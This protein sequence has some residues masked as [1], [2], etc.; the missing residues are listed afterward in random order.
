LTTQLIARLAACGA[1]RVFRCKDPGTDGEPVEVELI[2]EGSVRQAGERFRCDSQLVS[3]NDGLHLW[4][5]SFDCVNHDTFAVEDEFAGRIAKAV[6]EAF[7]HEA[8][9]Q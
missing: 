4:A 1:L 6:C 3:S 7:S 9:L 5:G 8:S 2:L